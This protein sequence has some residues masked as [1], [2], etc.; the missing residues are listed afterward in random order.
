MKNEHRLRSD[1]VYISLRQAAQK[2]IGGRFV[3]ETRGN[4][5]TYTSRTQLATKNISG[6]SLQGLVR[7]RVKQHS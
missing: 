2:V 5:E 3:D 6:L 7:N 4:M 1:S